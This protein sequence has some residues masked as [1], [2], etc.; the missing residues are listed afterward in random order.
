MTDNFIEYQRAFTRHGRHDHLVGRREGGTLEINAICGTPMSG[1]KDPRDA[2]Y[3]L[4][5]RC[6]ELRNPR[7]PIVED[8][9]MVEQ[10]KK[11]D[12]AEA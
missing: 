4:C 1:L 12:W 10:L 8:Q 5:P 6:A 2:E 7:R 3:P 11:G 9:W